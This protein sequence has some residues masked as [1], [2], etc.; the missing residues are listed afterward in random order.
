MATTTAKPAITDRPSTAVGPGP[1]KATVDGATASERRRKHVPGFELDC[2]TGA[3]VRHVGIVFV[4]GI[5]AQEPGETLLDWGGAIAGLLLDIRLA[6]DTAADPVIS[7]DLDPAPSKSRFIELQLPGVASD[8]ETTEEHWVMTEAWWAQRVRPPPFGKMAEWL[9]PRGA[10][11]RIV[12]AMLPREKNK[13]DARRRPEVM[14]HTMRRGDQHGPE[15]DAEFG[16]VVGQIVDPTGTPRANRVLGSFFTLGKLSAGLYL[17]AISGLLLVLY[18]ALRSIEKLVP[19]G[20]IRNGALTRP[21]DR[22]MLDWFGDVYVL[23]DDP[24]QAASV[25]GRLVDA[26]RDLQAARCDTIA[27]VAH[28]GGAIVSYMTLADPAIEDITVHRF[29]TLGEG[30]NLAWRLTIGDDGELDA[31]THRRYE[32]LYSNVFEQRPELQWDDF[33]ASEDPAPVGVLNPHGGSLDEVPLGQITSH[34]IWNRLAVAQ[35]HGSYWDNDE[36]FLLPLVR[37]LTTHVPEDVFKTP[38]QS[39]RRRRRLSILSVGRQLSLVAPTAAIVT[40]FALGSPFLHAASDAIAAAWSAIPGPTSSPR[41]STPSD[42]SNFRSSRRGSFSPKEDAGSSS[43]SSR[44]SR[45]TRLSLQSSDP[46]R[47]VARTT[48]TNGSITSWSS[49]RGSSRFRS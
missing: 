19:I 14:P 46:F 10:I 48:R 1:P 37:L 7:C 35:D 25:R 31:A 17:Q 47:G 30:L 45:S 29:I 9:G 8:G 28:S 38:D 3:D 6:E 26:L 44:Q 33:W 16:N 42:G 23:L 36:E 21:I 11:S 32:R 43:P 12:M 20:P 13:H 34:S 24:A 18:G 40:A 4:H 41:R 15:E 22:F 49:V 5:G 27:I 2:R 39:N